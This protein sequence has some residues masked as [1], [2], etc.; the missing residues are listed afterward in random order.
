L[1]SSN[2]NRMVE[3]ARKEGVPAYLVPD[4]TQ[5]DPAWLEGAE[6]VGVSSGASAPEVLVERLLKRLADLGF[7]RLETRE[8]TL[9]DVTFSLPPWLRAEENAVG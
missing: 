1:N 7:D 3:V 5:L 9:E 2:S 6:A 8:V 4:E